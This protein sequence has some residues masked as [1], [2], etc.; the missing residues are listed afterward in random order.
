[1]SE[2]KEGISAHGEAEHHLLKDEPF[3]AGI[4]ALVYLVHHPEGALHPNEEG[5]LQLPS[6]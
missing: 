3:V 1:M 6:R 2:D 4:H 5:F